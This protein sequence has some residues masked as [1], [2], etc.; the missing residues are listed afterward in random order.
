M[1]G[2]R[3]EI[4]EGLNKAKVFH[5]F[6]LGIDKRVRGWFLP[7]KT[8]FQLYN[9]LLADHG[10]KIF[11]APTID[12]YGVGDMQVGAKN[13]GFYIFNRTF[14][15]DTE[16][17]PGVENGFVVIENRLI[18]LKE[19]AI[20]FDK[21]ATTIVDLCAPLVFSAVFMVNRLAESIIDKDL[22]E[23][24]IADLI[25][26]NVCSMNEFVESIY[27]DQERKEVLSE[28]RLELQEFAAKYIKEASRNML[29]AL[30]IMQAAFAAVLEMHPNGEEY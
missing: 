6:T 27:T 11:I 29:I 18:L 1:F 30:N 20:T 19:H 12:F 10:F 13:K 26:E 9:K 25:T 23:E 14:D 3:F 7:I 17:V 16:L 21:G 2:K 24:D 28:M 4:E 22:S 15:R 5:P 8:E